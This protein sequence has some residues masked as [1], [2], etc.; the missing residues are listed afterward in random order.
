L[1][2]FS[3]PPLEM[4][5]TGGVSVVVPNNGNLE[6]LRDGENCLLYKKGNIEEAVSK[7]ELIVK[8]KNLRDRL[9]KNGLET[10]RLYDW[11]IVEKDILDLYK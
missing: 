11:E 8:D 7:I 9:I 1:E 2:S 6:F 3:Y 10:S 4:M 5:A